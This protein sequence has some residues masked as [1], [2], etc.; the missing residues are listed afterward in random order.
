MQRSERE[1]FQ[2]Q[3]KYQNT[4]NRDN[5]D[6]VVALLPKGQRERLKQ[7]AAESGVSLG[8]WIRDAIEEKLNKT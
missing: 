1:K 4:Y 2:N 5:Y 6:R 7:L 3:F 8:Q